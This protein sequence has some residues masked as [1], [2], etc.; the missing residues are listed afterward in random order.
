M[1]YA[2]LCAN[3]QKAVLAEPAGA[4]F[5]LRRLARKGWRAGQVAPALQVP[6]YL[7]VDTDCT[8]TRAGLT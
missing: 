4:A 8:S 1:H 5:W 3:G 2:K 6:R 7:A